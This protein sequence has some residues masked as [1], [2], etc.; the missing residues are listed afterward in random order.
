MSTCMP[1]VN[2]QAKTTQAIENN[3]YS[4]DIFLDLVKAFDSVDHKILS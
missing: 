1:P 4:I 3:G 2:I